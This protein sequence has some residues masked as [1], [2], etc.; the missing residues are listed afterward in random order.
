MRKILSVLLAALMLF[1]M[2][3]TTS[4]GKSPADEGEKT[5]IYA[6]AEEL[7]QS[8]AGVA[9]YEKK[10][11]GT[12][13]DIDEDGWKTVEEYNK[14]GC[15][16][17]RIFYGEDGSEYVRH[18]YEYDNDGKLSKR[19][20]KNI[21]EAAA[22]H[23]YTYNQN[24]SIAEINYENGYYYDD[25]FGRVQISKQVFAYDDSGKIL[26]SAEYRFDT[27]EVFIKHEYTYDEENFR[28]TDTQLR[29]EKLNSVTE[30]YY[31]DNWTL[32]KAETRDENGNITA[33]REYYENGNLKYQF[34][35]YSDFGFKA[36]FNE[37]GKVT[38]QISTSVGGRETSRMKYE[39]NDAGKLIQ[40][41][42]YDASGNIVESKIYD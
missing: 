41:T 22:V 37:N 10:R 35:S 3:F 23:I 40:K 16:V 42:T 39:Y 36:Y 11:K 28:I 20:T 34:V 30:N 8:Q 24:G 15:L 26:S 4:C 2:V 14:D 1:G 38:E 21:R 12:Y 33:T 17:K 27:G 18:E 29:E 13:E 5:G 19:T 25:N 6:A 7:V 9:R 31:S 32:S